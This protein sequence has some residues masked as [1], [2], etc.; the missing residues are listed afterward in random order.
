[1]KTTHNTLTHLLGA[2]DRLEVVGTNPDNYKSILT[3][4]FIDGGTRKIAI[5]YRFEEG[6]YMNAPY[7]YAFLV[8]YDQ[9]GHRRS[10]IKNGSWGCHGEDMMEFKLWFAKKLSH[11]N[12]VQE[13]RIEDAQ[14]NI[15]NFLS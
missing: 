15:T 11:A 12:E 13:L 14:H 5:E 1:M 6:G 9:N 10:V 4:T 2:W 8:M 7:I 3:N